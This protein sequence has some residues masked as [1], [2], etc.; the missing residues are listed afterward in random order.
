MLSPS[1]ALGL[2]V[3]SGWILFID[4]VLF[5]DGAKGF[6]GLGIEVVAGFERRDTGVQPAA[7]EAEIA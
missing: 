7:G 5:Q 1:F 6:R 4:N 2:T 3:A